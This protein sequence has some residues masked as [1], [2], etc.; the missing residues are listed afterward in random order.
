MNSESAIVEI[1]NKENQFILGLP[2][3]NIYRFPKKNYD[4]KQQ[5]VVI[6]DLNGDKINEVLTVLPLGDKN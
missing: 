4:F 3:K 2:S 5:N 1:Y 6:A